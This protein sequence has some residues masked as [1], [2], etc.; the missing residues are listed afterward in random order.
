MIQPTDAKLPAPAV[1]CRVCG[2]R[3]QLIV[4]ACKACSRCHRI[5]AG[6]PQGGILAD[7][8][9]T[10][11][12][13]PTNDMTFLDIIE[14]VCDWWG[15]RKGYHDERPWAIAVQMSLETKKR[16]L[17]PWQIELVHSVAAFLDARGEQ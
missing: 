5:G 12:S 7:P 11:P 10:L 2:T 14:M 4:C 9:D 1:T 3:L 15:A 8:N 6:E 13:E 16:Y 17:A